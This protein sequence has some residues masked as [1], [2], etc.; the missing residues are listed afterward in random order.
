[1]AEGE[2]SNVCVL[3]IL[4]QNMAKS[5]INTSMLITVQKNY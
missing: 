5:H 1:V 2:V 3:I 4:K